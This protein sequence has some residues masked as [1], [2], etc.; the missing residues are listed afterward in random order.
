MFIAL[1]VGAAS[2]H[3]ATSLPI[4]PPST[5]TT[6]DPASAT[7]RAPGAGLSDPAVVPWGLN[8]L[9][10]ANLPSLLRPQVEPSVA[11]N[12]ANRYEMVAGY[13]DFVADSAPGI[14][15]SLDGGKTW[16]A[17]PGGPILG[18]PPG[19]LWGNRNATGWLAQ[20]DSA[21]AWGTNRAVYFSMIGFQNNA[22]PPPP[23]TCEPGG[24]YVYRS[25]DGG[26]TWT[27]PT[28]GPAV[29]NTRTIF[30]DKPFVA[31]DADAA[32][33]HAGS[34]YLVW[35]DDEYS[36]CPQ[37]FPQNFVTR[38]IMFSRST[39]G[40][41][42]WSAPAT[43]GG[44]CVFGP[45][46]A[47]GAT[48]RLHVVWY[49]C[50]G[51]V[52]KQLVRTSTDGGASFAVAV[53]AASGFTSCPSPLPGATFRVVAPLPTIATDPVDPML[54]YVAWA[55]CTRASQSDVFFSRSTDGGATWTLP[56]R[57]NDDGAS[58]PR[59]QFFPWLAVDDR[60]M[61]RLIWGDDRL[62]AGSAGGHFY[63]IFAAESTNRGASFGANVRVTTEPSNPDID[64]GGTFI[65][66]YFGIA[67]CAT[68][69][70]GDTRAGNQDIFA[71]EY[72][73]NGNGVVDSC[74][75]TAVGVAS[76]TARR[77]G[78]QVAVRRRITPAATFRIWQRPAP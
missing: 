73:A 48:G 1:A 17:P 6:I 40:G 64:F 39:D 16:A 24:V 33:P 62:D 32:S 76:P 67:P 47:V 41:V 36:G 57:V 12:P 34:V 43:L 20:G 27:L 50:N 61:V 53:P 44:G 38:R 26:D 28:G 11:S 2:G 9:V 15:K 71:S 52:A 63:D 77:L 19:F 30:R 66:D 42:T 70:W 37:S 49:D 8:A 13:A 45:V 58:N 75:P 10:S 5:V 46:P 68:P 31:A 3:G 29:A 4:P 65:G 69:V 7:L 23:G 59:D 55:S 21:L 35:D 22:A 18:P 51:G 25:S 56:L 60:R 74:Q 72:D 78:P 54:V 14:S